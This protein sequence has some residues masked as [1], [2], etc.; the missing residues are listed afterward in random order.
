MFVINPT[1]PTVQ[2]VRRFV[3]LVD[4]VGVYAK[5]STQKRKE[6]QKRKR[7]RKIKKNVSVCARY[8]S[9]YVEY[10]LHVGMYSMYGV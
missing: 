5:G 6:K 9:G 7:K 4:V 3:S 8:G 1:V 10:V 2:P